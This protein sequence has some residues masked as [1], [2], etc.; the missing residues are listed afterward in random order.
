MTSA[1]DMSFDLEETEEETPA[2]TDE[3]GFLGPDGDALEPGSDIIGDLALS[4]DELNARMDSEPRDTTTVEE[5]IYA[6]QQIFA[7]RLNRLEVAPSFA[8]TLNDPYVRRRALGLGLNYWWSNVLAIGF[9]F[10][11]YDLEGFQSESDLNF[12]VRRS[13]RL[14][15]PI[16][17]WQLGAHMN[18]TY[19]PLYGKFMAFNKWIF[20]WDAYVIGGVGFQR[21][22]PI[23]IIDPEIRTFD[24]EMRLAFNVGIGLRIF[25]SRFLT[26]FA[27]FRDYL[28]LERFES[29]DVALGEAR[30]DKSTWLADSSELVNNVTV[31]I[32]IT[33]FF[34]FSF[35]YKL[36][37]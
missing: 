28:Y 6:V 31:Q 23:A 1:Q 3:N 32:G 4:D 19:V 30:N 11:W 35:E 22:R 24:Y 8:F 2:E 12:F 13:A 14:A 36:P 34:P 20:Q 25:L 9:N 21:T 15:V 5:E 17:E 7:L 16:T 27:E 18:F 37:K 29:L 33:L 26:V 10:L